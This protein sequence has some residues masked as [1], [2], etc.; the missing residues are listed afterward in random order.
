MRI[1]TDKGKGGFNDDDDGDDDVDMLTEIRQEMGKA[2]DDDHVEDEEAEMKAAI[3]ASA[4]R[5]K[6]KKNKKK[7]TLDLTQYHSRGVSMEIRY[8]FLSFC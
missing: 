3:E 7:R 5:K 6:D 4:Q 1:P 2:A 8:A